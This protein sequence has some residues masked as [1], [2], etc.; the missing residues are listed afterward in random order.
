MENLICDIVSEIDGRHGFRDAIHRWAPTGKRKV[1]YKL[2]QRTDVVVAE[3]LRGNSGEVC[4]EA[5]DFAHD[6]LAAEAAC[7]SDKV[8]VSGI[9][10][11]F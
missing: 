6:G 11:R 2:F 8:G 1:K 3:P 4:V 5:F 7:K 9:P 10:K